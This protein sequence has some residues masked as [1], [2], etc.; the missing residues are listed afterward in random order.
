MNDKLKIL[1]EEPSWKEKYLPQ[2]IGEWLISICCFAIGILIYKS[3][4]LFN[5][6]WITLLF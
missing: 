2:S 5:K 1:N 4:M 3:L 6:W